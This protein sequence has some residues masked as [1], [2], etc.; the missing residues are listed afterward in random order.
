MIRYPTTGVATRRENVRML[1]MFQ[2]CSWR[3]LSSLRVDFRVEAS[4]AEVEAGEGC[5]IQ[6]AIS[7][8]KATWCSPSII[9]SSIS[10]ETNENVE[11]RKPL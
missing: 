8:G 4:L 9:Q 1:G 6:S 11:L 5:C 7:S 3:G 2:I 10:N